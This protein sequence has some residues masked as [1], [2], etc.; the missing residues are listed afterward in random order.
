LLGY[1]IF[2]TNEASATIATTWMK[3]REKKNREKHTINESSNFVFIKYIY[4]YIL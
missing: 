3:G 2:G 4:K 1:S